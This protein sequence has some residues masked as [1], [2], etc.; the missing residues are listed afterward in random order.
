LRTGRTRWVLLRVRA[1]LLWLR[2][3]G[4][5]I[6]FVGVVSVMMSG[7]E[8]GAILAPCEV[9]TPPVILKIMWRSLLRIIW[10]RKLG[11]CE[12]RLADG[13]LG[14]SSS[15]WLGLLIGAATHQLTIQLSAGE[16]RVG[17]DIEPHQHD[18]DRAERAIGPVV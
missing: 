16:D 11:P 5:R 10:R 12:L 7:R 1:R 18:R 15:V 9:R 6:V 3:F 2:R 4:M 8:E 17:G 14:T 13:Q